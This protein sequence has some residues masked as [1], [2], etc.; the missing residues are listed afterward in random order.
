MPLAGDPHVVPAIRGHPD[1]PAGRDS[2]QGGEC[3]PRR[4]LLLLAAE[5]APE[6]RDL[7][8]R[9][10]SSAD[11]SRPPPPAGSHSATAWRSAPAARR[12]RVGWPARSAS[13]GRRAP[14][15]R[16]R[17][18]RTRPSRTRPTP[19][20]RRRWRTSGAGPAPGPP[21]TP[22]GRRGWPGAPPS[23]PSRAGRPATRR[24]RNRRSRA[25]P[26]RRRSGPL[27]RRAG[28]RR[29]RCVLIWLSPGMSAA[30]S[31]A[32]TPGWPAAAVTSRAVNLA[33]ACGETATIACR[34][35]AG[36]GRSPVNRAAPRTSRSLVSALI[37]QP[38]PRCDAPPAGRAEPTGRPAGPGRPSTSA[39]RPGWPSVSAA[40]RRWV[41]RARL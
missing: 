33:W 14:G 8:A 6:S 31:T 11:R 9:R 22:R 3:G 38:P 5:A 26:A 29:G 28:A 10:G 17:P 13:R 36:R 19:H 35:P 20:R 30:V 21:R 39:A 34:P 2:A 25:P 12:R 23:R 4:G 7:A 32:R 37:G 41:S 1:R 24:R 16:A 18:D 15:R 27:R 40:S